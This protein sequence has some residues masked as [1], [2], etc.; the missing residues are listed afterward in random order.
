MHLIICIFAS[1]FHHYMKRNCCESSFSASTCEIP[2]LRRSL[3]GLTPS[4]G[5]SCGIGWQS[6]HGL[7]T[8]TH[9]HNLWRAP[10]WRQVDGGDNEPISSQ[11]FTFPFALF[12]HMPPRLKYPAGAWGWDGEYRWLHTSAITTFGRSLSNLSAFYRDLVV[13]EDLRSEEK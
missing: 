5:F 3:R 9:T 1:E 12:S 7:H 4:A 11:G 10:A 6:G 8:H 13:Y 2:S